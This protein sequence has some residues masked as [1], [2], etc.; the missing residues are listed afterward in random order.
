M[1]FSTARA[2]LH[3]LLSLFSFAFAAPRTTLVRQVSNQTV[4]CEQT[5]YGARDNCPPG[6]AIAYPITGKREVAGGLG[7]YKDPITFAASPRL[8]PIHSIIYV[9]RLK[10]YF[11]MDDDCEEC[12]DEYNDNKKCHVD[13]WMGP[14][15]LTPANIAIERTDSR[16]QQMLL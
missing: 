11:R 13:L 10:K 4:L 14:P 3:L 9:P 6:G 8:F 5:F 15:H 12:I 16:K 2:G 7:T 1:F